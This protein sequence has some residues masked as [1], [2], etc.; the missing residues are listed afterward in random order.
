ML[1]KDKKGFTLTEVIATLAILG[2][3]LLIAIPGVGK[4]Q[5]NF[6]KNYYEQLDGSVLA[7]AKTYYK[8]NA[9]QRPVNLLEASFLYY[10]TNEKDNLLIDKKYIDT[11]NQ[12]NKT[13]PCTGKVVAVKVQDDYKY[14]NC[15][16]CA[17]KNYGEDIS[18]TYD[19]N[20]CLFTEDDSIIKGYDINSG[21]KIYIN[22][23]KSGDLKND[24][25][26]PE[27]VTRY[28]VINS[29][30]KLLYEV[31]N[32]ENKI[33]PTNV[34]GVNPNKTGVYKTSFKINDEDIKTTEVEVYQHAA[35]ILK[36]ENLSKIDNTYYA[37]GNIEIVLEDYSTFS[38]GSSEIDGYKYYD[39]INKKW[40]DVCSSE[41]STLC[42]IDTT[43]WN[44]TTKFRVVGKYPDSSTVPISI[45][46]KK[47]LGRESNEYQIVSKEIEIKLNKD[48]GEGGSDSATVWK[49]YKIEEGIIPPTKSGFSFKGYKDALGKY[50]YYDSTGAPATDEKLLVDSLELIADW[51]ETEKNA[52][53]FEFVSTDY[54]YNLIQ[55]NSDVEIGESRYF[56][57]MVKKD[58]TQPT[59]ITTTPTLKY[60]DGS[61]VIMCQLDTDAAF[62]NKRT[63]YKDTHYRY[64]CGRRDYTSA[65][66]HETVAYITYQATSTKTKTLEASITHI[67]PTYTLTYDD[68]NGFGCTSKTGTYGGTWGALCTPSQT[69][70]TFGGWYTGTNGGGTNITDNS[71]VEGNLTVYAKWTVNTYT[72]TYNLDGGAN[73]SSNPNSYTYGIGVSS[74]ANPTKTGYTF[75]GWYSDSAK[76]TKIT[77]ISSTSTGA[78]TL[79]AKWTANT[80]TVVFNGNDNTSGSTASKKCTYGEDC[81][82]TTNGF[83][84]TNWTWTKWNTYAGGGGTSYTTTV[85][86]LTSINNDTVT[87]YAI[88]TPDCAG[89]FIQPTDGDPFNGWYR[90]DVS[91]NFIYDNNITSVLVTT[92]SNPTNKYKNQWT[93][94]G[95][96][97]TDTNGTTWYVHMGTFYG[98]TKTCSVVVKRD[99]VAPTIEITNL[100]YDYEKIGDDKF[101]F[102][103]ELNFKDTGSTI[104][105]FEEECTQFYYNYEHCYVSGYTPT[106]GSWTKIDNNLHYK[107]SNNVYVGLKND[108]YGAHYRYLSEDT[109][110]WS[111]SSGTKN[112]VAY[113]RVADKAGNWKYTKRIYKLDATKKRMTLVTS[114]NYTRK[115][116]KEWKDVNSKCG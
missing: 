1:R 64:F 14:A 13:D 31:S 63:E 5:E 50:Y 97:T 72:I 17:G 34:T 77:S 41:N 71:K 9:M 4:L 20:I 104:K 16:E 26:V 29:E 6:K 70:H 93:T 21:I 62:F 52:P 85:K 22:H 105:G 78:K 54:N 101:Y 113:I 42:K 10:N 110:R 87:L 68:G 102:A 28:G 111:P 103:A 55:N 35:P 91:L 84:K 90:A 27:K 18:T 109:L 116:E 56:N 2:I 107:N 36:E 112:V 43:N 75:N 47:Q 74:F 81:T 51:E 40:V 100:R 11:I 65:G 88:W 73:N 37:K 86:N 44:A 96:Q 33:C 19:E 24:L 115:Q 80:Y 30:T 66:E 83:K 108:G 48:G 7:A 89:N 67:V 98:T 46:T 53:V 76:T 49:G 3:I 38:D 32:S 39:S 106:C 58:G 114:E 25:C 12:Y 23:Y 45:K 94:S 60:G 69:G 61:N 92:N 95:S 99:T 59:N 57:V 15:R 8:D 79:Y 82:L